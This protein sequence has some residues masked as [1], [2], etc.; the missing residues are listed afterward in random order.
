MA[1][2]DIETT[3]IS[4]RAGGVWGLVL[5]LGTAS[6]LA[7]SATLATTTTSA[8]RNA[9][10]TL[11]LNLTLDL[12]LV[13]LL[14]LRMA[15]WIL[16]PTAATTTAS[17]SDGKTRLQGAQHAWGSA[18]RRFGWQRRWLLLWL[19]LRA[20]LHL[21]EWVGEGC[22]SLDVS[23]PC[24][25]LFW[26]GCSRFDGGAFKHRR[27]HGGLLGSKSRAR[28]GCAWCSQGRQGR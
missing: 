8:T 21:A 20:G 17:T 12:L 26:R 13:T 22:S 6:V 27:G 28:R 4:R 3:T 5:I 19:G 11:T 1:C 24:L 25:N 9:C 2:L 10:T 14:R 23:F 16:L 18:C 7:P 15:E